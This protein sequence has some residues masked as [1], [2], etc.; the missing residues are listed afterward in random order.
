MTGG[1]SN[2]ALPHKLPKYVK[3]VHSKGRTYYYFDTSLKADGKRIYTRLPDLRSMEWGGAY[4][5]CMGH[6]TRGL[7]AGNVMRIPRLV[8][9]YQRSKPYKDMRASS[10]RLYDIALRKLEKLLPTAPVARI[11]RL[12]MRK[13]IDGMADTPGAANTFK[14]VSGALFKWAVEHEYMSANP[15]E[16]IEPI[17]MGEHEEWPEPVLDAALASDDDRVRLLTHMLYFTA[18]RINDVLSMRWTD[19]QDG[20]I[21]VTQRKTGKELSIPIHEDLAAELAKTLRRGLLICT[22]DRGLPLHEETA[23][24]AL[25]A[26]CAEHGAK[27]VPHGLRKNAVIALLEAGCT[28]AET[29]SISGQSLRM[30]EHYA[31]GRNQRKLSTAAVL[32]W[33]GTTRERS[34]FG[35]TAK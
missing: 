5:A 30:V 16:G 26:F 2:R 19:I 21:N 3:I 33:Q 8:D 27:R 12:D 31:K 13:L 7:T 6:R 35:K 32:K 24:Q 1:R 20:R 18:Q 23:R 22:N 4:S 34:N 29:A 14:A 15:V 25:K 10:R 9:L 11:T 28:I 17:P